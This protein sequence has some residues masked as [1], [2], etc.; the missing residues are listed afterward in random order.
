MFRL[1][2]AN[3]QS[4]IRPALLLKVRNNKTGISLPAANGGVGNNKASGNTLAL[5]CQ[6]GR[7]NSTV[8]APKVDSYISH[9]RKDPLIQEAVDLELS[10]KLNYFKE[11]LSLAHQYRFAKDLDGRR[12]FVSTVDNLFKVFED[13][14]LRLAYTSKDLYGY[15][16]LLNFSV[17]Q[18][19]TNRLSGSKNRDSDQY[20]NQNLHDEVL[21][22]T[23]VLN[24]C[25]AITDGEFNKIL[26]E[27]ILLY[28]LY[29]M[30]QFLLF[31]EMLNLW[32]NG[33]NDPETGKVFLKE[34]ILAVILP[35]AYEQRRFSYEEI[36]HIYEVNTKD[37]ES[38]LHELLCSIGKIFIA[39]G[40]YSRGLDALEALL[41]LYEKRDANS[42]Q[43]LN[44]LGELHL[45][46][47]GHCKDIRISKHFFDK[48][49]QQD[50]PYYVALKVPFIQSLLQ[51]CYESNAPLDD[52]IYFWKSTINYYANGKMNSNLNSRYAILNNSFFTIFFKMYPELTME[53][54]TKLKDVLTIYS[55]IKPIDEVLLNT[56]ISNF[57]WKDKGVLEQLIQNYYI[58]DVRRTPVSYRICLKKTGEISD[59]TNEEILLKW[60]ES[61]SNLDLNGFTYIPIADWAALRDA[62]ILSEFSDE[63]KDLYLAVAS[64]YK[65]Y[66]QDQRSCV[67]FLKFW[68]KNRVHMDDIL[69]LTEGDTSTFSDKYDLLNTHFKNLRPNIDYKTLS[70]MILKS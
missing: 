37:I 66:I 54:F 29:S 28:L 22:R 14:D 42:S 57:T 47:I 4:S 39:E 32:E 12:A 70:S 58:Y 11:Q 18:N 62:T 51:N 13:Q 60:D 1:L 25:E 44:S 68:L 3:A 21:I 6:Y 8:A 24:L 50:L 55:E 49:I 59:Y 2:S 61:L 45:N 40:D 56:L 10:T 7:D 31:S 27:N 43:V 23:A 67:R 26:N 52:I 17:Y 19:R 63:R 36:L 46:F 33:V 35:I 16:Q 64:K 5:N 30:K 15:A 20:Q 53:S 34:K 41:A 65:D 69:K 38:V 9:A 48:V